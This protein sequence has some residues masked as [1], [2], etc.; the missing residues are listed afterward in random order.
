MQLLNHFG[1]NRRLLSTLCFCAAFVVTAFA[2][3]S[4]TCQENLIG[5]RL[6]A[7]SPDGKTLAFVYRGDIWSVPS[8]GGRAT[9]LTCTW[10][11]IRTPSGLR[12]ANGSLS[13]A[14][15]TAIVIFSSCLPR[16]HTS[17]AH[18]QQR[19]RSPLGMVSDSTEIL[20]SATRDGK[21]PGIFS[22]NLDLV[23]K[24]YAEDYPKLYFPGFS[25]DGKTIVYGRFGFPWIRPRYYGSGACRSISWMSPLPSAKPWWMTRNSISGLDSC[26]PVRK[27]SPSPS[28]RGL[29]VFRL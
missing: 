4:Q 28:A 14:H 21:G 19:S 8:E 18:L 12:M 11:W 1:K 20:F 24:K 10:T 9:P 13:P 23:T 16:R 5:A 29:P 17:P 22:V 3:D 27:S 15:A 2:E 25:P 6:P 7:L 26:P